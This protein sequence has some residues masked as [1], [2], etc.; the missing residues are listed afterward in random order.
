MTKDFFECFGIEP[1]MQEGREYDSEGNVCSWYPVYPTI[2]AEIVLKL[3]EIILNKGTG[4]SYLNHDKGFEFRFSYAYKNFEYMTKSSM[5]KTR[6][7]ALLNLCIQLKDSIKDK[8][9]ELFV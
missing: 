7:E 4:I 8:V 1:E 9:K 5:G 2:T 6:Q 3:E